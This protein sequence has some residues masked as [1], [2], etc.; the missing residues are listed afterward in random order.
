MLNTIF[1]RLCP[2]CGGDIESVRLFKGA[3]C[4][5]CLP[6]IVDC[7]DL[8]LALLEEGGLKG[9]AQQLLVRDELERFEEMFFKATG[10]KLW[11]IQRAWAKRLIMGESFAL[12]APTGVGKT[13]L[14]A[15]YALFSAEKKRKVLFIAPT[16]SL[17]SQ[18]YFRLKEYAQKVLPDVADDIVCYSSLLK[19]SEKACALQRL[20]DRDYLI[21][22]ITSAMLSRGF[23]QYFKGT[24]FDLIVA[25]DVDA[26]LKSSKNV[27]RIL[28][29]LGFNEDLVNKAYTL[30]VKKINL[31]RAKAAGKSQ[32]YEKLRDEISKLQEE[33]AIDVKAAT[34]GQLVVSSATGRAR[35]IKPKVFRELLGFEAGRTIEYLRNVID[36]FHEGPLSEESLVEISSTLGPGGII[37]VARDY[38][39]EAAKS[40]AKALDEAGIRASLAI[41][42]KAKAIERFAKGEIDVLVGVATYYGYV[43]RGIDLPERVRYV[44]FY[45]VPRTRTSLE[46]ALLNPMKL[47][48]VLGAIGD[49]ECKDALRTLSRAF[50]NLSYGEFKLLGKAL[51]E[52]LPVEGYLEKV[53]EM[54]RHA[55]SL[56]LD[57]LA[58]IGRLALE[59][60][61]IDRGYV[62]VPDAMTYI[63]ASGR[64]SR[65]LEGRMTLGLSVVLMDDEALLKALEYRLS[66]LC[67]DVKFRSLKEINIENLKKEMEET[68]K[69]KGV[70]V[71][72]PIKT[73]LLVVESPN[74]ARTIANFF[75]K[76]SKRKMGS[77]TVYEVP[78]IDDK[79]KV[80]RICSIVATKGHLFDLTIDEVGVHGVVIQG[81]EY[82]PVYSPISKC[83]ICGHQFS[84]IRNECPRCGSSLI[85]SSMEVVHALRKLAFEVDEVIIATDPDTEG[86]KIAWDVAAVVSPYNK[87]I[88]RAE[89]HEITKKA[90]LEAL[91]NLRAINE[92]AV[93]AQV[94][95]RIDD[96]WIGFELSKL[97]WKVYGKRWLGAGRVQTPVLGWIINQYGKWKSG[98]CY[99]VV[100][101]LDGGVKAKF[102]YD[103]KGS[104]MEGLAAAEQGVVIEEV[105]LE[106]QV[107]KPAPPY[108]TDDL[109]YDA[110]RIYGFSAPYT[111]KLAQNLFEAGLITYHRT[112]STRVSAAGMSIAKAYLQSIGAAHLFKPRHW[113]EGGAHECIRPT[114]PI[115]PEDLVSKLMT[116]ELQLHVDIG[117][118]HIKLYKLIF[119]RFVASQMK[120]AR[121]IRAVIKLKLGSS[122]TEIDGIARIIEPGFTVIT[123]PQQLPNNLLR[124]GR[125]P[126]I[127]AKIVRTSRER[128]WRHGD[129][130]RVMKERRIG[131]PSTYAKILEA[132]RRHGYVVESKKAKYLIPTKLGI[133]VHSYLASNFS[134]LVSEE[135]TRRL[136]VLME[137]V[138]SGS[139]GFKDAISRIRDELVQANLLTTVERGAVETCS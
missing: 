14:L 139:I 54:T 88:F 136:E 84:S 83:L 92:N 133:E 117:K 134:E 122:T 68:R 131:R 113:G 61:V 119:D 114:M 125:V 30:V 115:S 98:R 63:Q 41:S 75:A 103:D 39:T 94:V 87:K 127:A 17:A 105:K 16:S 72:V 93:A 128:L 23:D 31:L 99:A 46:K 51:A 9:M 10:Y 81:D 109:L 6:G 73:S 24:R 86:E 138:A 27:D 80:Y 120:E 18:I 4:S 26:V 100:V 3:P 12:I 28:L 64:C 71:E 21:A 43:V 57:K 82:R 97:L 112:D 20:K 32:L 48:R 95:R 11:N 40:L 110:S 65:L 13:T 56:A 135:A 59:D 66:S 34:A 90:I 8:L 67:L 29:L 36:A 69:R 22:S 53:V 19:S 116:G 137:L 89:V 5:K 118:N 124:P 60:M 7:K 15:V 77:V 52:E 37:F 50:K 123:R 1:Q 58:K 74:K 70:C 25:D 2:N 107:L 38:G 45:G 106:E 91:V 35:G 33:I 104:A 132:L 62:F 44:I 101:D 47:L 102:L 108:T 55:Y 126:V 42:G 78:I 111:M 79:R 129:V 85:K 49:D 76:P 121:V 96:R 130:V